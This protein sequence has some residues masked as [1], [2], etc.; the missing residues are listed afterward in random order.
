MPESREE[1]LFSLVSIFRDES[2]RTTLEIE[3]RIEPIV[4]TADR[5]L[6]VD[7]G[8]RESIDMVRVL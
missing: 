5:P 4:S 6:L 1:D 2:G 7:G 3:V 8:L